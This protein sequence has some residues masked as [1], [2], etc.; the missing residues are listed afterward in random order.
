V[1]DIFIVNEADRARQT[2]EEGW[3]DLLTML[4]IDA[5]W[6]VHNVIH[7]FFQILIGNRVQQNSESAFESVG[8]NNAYNVGVLYSLKVL[9]FDHNLL[10]GHAAIAFDCFAS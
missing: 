8:A 6:L 2:A 7:E 5:I 3:Y 1:F 4:T 10:F 9:N